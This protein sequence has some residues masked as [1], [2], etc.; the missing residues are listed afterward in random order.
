MTARSWHFFRESRFAARLTPAKPPFPALAPTPADNLE[1]ER[2]ISPTSL[3]VD[4]SA[5]DDPSAYPVQVTL[6]RL[7][8]PKE[9]ANG[10]VKS[11]MYRSN[12][13]ATEDAANGANGHDTESDEVVNCKFVVGCDGARS[14]VRR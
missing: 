3:K 1:V 4:E 7:P 11:G 12:L 14:W 10:D 5:L 2:L 9:W 6:R 8:P 13:F